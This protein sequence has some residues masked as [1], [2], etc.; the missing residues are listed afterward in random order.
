[1]RIRLFQSDHGDCLLLESVDGSKMLVDGGL[2]KS[3]KSH[4]IPVLVRFQ[5]DEPIDL[6]CVSHVD[7]DHIG[8]ILT[9]MKN[10]VEWRVF[11]H[12]E[13]RGLTAR[14]LSLKKE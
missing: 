3:F 4:V 7:Q 9:Y 11:R 14:H 6:L 2:N 13:S 10:L 8:G 12:R 1:M 5:D